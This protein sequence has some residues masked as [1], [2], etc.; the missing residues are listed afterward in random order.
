MS[1]KSESSSFEDLAAAAELEAAPLTSPDASDIP[2][3]LDVLGSGHLLRRTITEGKS[4]LRPLRGDICYLNYKGCLLNS[5]VI[6]NKENFE[7]QIGDGDVIQGIDLV[8][9][10]MRE[11]EISELQISSRF[12]YGEIGMAPDIPPLAELLYTVELVSFKPEPDLD[13]FSIQERKVIGNKKRERG[14]WWYTMQEPMMAI[15]CYRRAIEYLD[16][17]KGG[18]TDPTADGKIE[19]A[20][21][22]LH[23][24][25]DDRIKAYNNMAAAQMKQGSYD[26]ALGSVE[27]VLNVQP[28]NVKALFRKGKILSYKNDVAEALKVVRRALLLSPDD[29]AIKAEL[30]RL[31]E[32]DKKDSQRERDLARKML[33]G[34]SGPES[35]SGSGKGEKPKKGGGKKIIVWGSV[36]FSLA[37]GVISIALYKYK[38]V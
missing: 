7:V 13:T 14:N 20:S 4:D 30:T 35:K 19:F 10:L 1:D 16:E 2:Q 18:I 5:T 31:E 3:W 25:L 34:H 26:I 37:I 29:K 21:E 32:R 38:I 8:L 15:Q 23:S 33:G 12:G 11:G 27:K 9:P 6:E 24:L 36:V 28:N 22:E 17:T